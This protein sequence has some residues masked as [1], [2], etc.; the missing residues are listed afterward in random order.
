MPVAAGVCLAAIASSTYWFYST[1]LRTT[2]KVDAIA[3][4]VQYQTG[5]DTVLFLESIRGSFRA[6]N[7]SC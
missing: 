5:L 4:V 1:P 7:R 3:K 6:P 2:P